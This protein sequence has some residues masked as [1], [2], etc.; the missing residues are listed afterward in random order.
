[1][2]PSETPFFNSNTDIVIK[3]KLCILTLPQITSLKECCWFLQA[4]FQE[5]IRLQMNQLTEIEFKVQ[6]IYRRWYRFTAQS[7][8]EFYFQTGSMNRVIT[9]ISNLTFYK[10]F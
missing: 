2:S 8:K 1:M 6:N 5:T 10:M 3:I 4:Y 7:P 9:K